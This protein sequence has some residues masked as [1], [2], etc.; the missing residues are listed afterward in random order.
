MGC[1]ADRDRRARGDA[2][3]EVSGT[4]QRNGRW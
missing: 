4:F 1:G 2:G 3:G